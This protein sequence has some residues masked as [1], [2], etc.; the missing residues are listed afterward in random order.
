MPG[1]DPPP[2][3]AVAVHD[4]AAFWR[5]LAE[6]AKVRGL[7]K[8]EWALRASTLAG[9]RG[10]TRSPDHKPFSAKTLYDRTANGRRVD[11]DEAQWFVQAV[12][13]LN[14]WSWRAAWERAEQR[15]LAPPEESSSPPP[16]APADRVPSAPLPVDHLPGPR[17]PENRWSR[18]RVL[19]VGA[20]AGT[21][22]AGLALVATSPWAGPNPASGIPVGPEA[23]PSSPVGPAAETVVPTGPGASTS[24]ATSAK[25]AA[26]ADFDRA[27]GRFALHDD[28]ADGRSAIL[29]VRIDGGALET[30]YN[31]RGRTDADSPAKDVELR[32][33][34]PGAPIEYRVCVGEYGSPV[35]ERSCGAWTTDTGP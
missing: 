24:S 22:V 7:S 23:A 17:S 19:K 11:W 30:V 3:P 31:S 9:R 18:R 34:T 6:E 15:W 2:D 12:P 1:A 32:G 26:H 20:V 13:G 27:R 16:D 8:S 5:G 28:R 25:R 21:V 4:F 10:Q 35:P 14:G 29:Q 33:V